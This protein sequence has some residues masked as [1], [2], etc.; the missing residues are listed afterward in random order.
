VQIYR[1]EAPIKKFMQEMLKEVQYCQKII[2]TILKKPSKM[3]DE[4]EQHF[5]AAKECHICNQAYNQ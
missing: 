5:Q 2:A 4:D 3:S 1:G